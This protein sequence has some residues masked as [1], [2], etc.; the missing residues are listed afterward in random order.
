MC[1]Q[2]SLAIPVYGSNGI[3]GQHTEALIEEPCIVIGRKGSAGALNK[4]LNPSWTTDVSYYVIPPKEIDFDYIF[5]ALKSL[6]LD[7]LGKVS[8]LD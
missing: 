7:S 4:S 1:V 6:N 3:V 5:L 8:S 2:N